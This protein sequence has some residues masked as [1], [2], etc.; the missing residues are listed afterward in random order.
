MSDDDVYCIECD[1]QFESEAMLRTHV[2]LKHPDLARSDSDQYASEVST[3]HLEDRDHPK[4]E[5]F[6]YRK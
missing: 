5:S 3:G 2:L 1:E 6:G 4:G